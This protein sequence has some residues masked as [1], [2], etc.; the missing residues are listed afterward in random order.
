[1]PPK[2]ALIADQS[3]PQRSWLARAVGV[4]EADVTEVDAGWKALWHLAE[5]SYDLVIASRLPDLPAV[6]VLAMVRT[7][8]LALPF[9]L[10]VPFYSQAVHALVHRSGAAELVA[11]WYDAVAVRAAAERLLRPT[12][13]AIPSL[14]RS[15]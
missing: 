9:L 8:G 14:A 3:P 15:L 1:L 13:Q 11:D 7:A 2:R 10:I 12:P 6:Q 4:V 5:Q